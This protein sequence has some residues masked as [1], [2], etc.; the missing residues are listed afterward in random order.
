VERQRKRRSLYLGSD[1]YIQLAVPQEAFPGTRYHS[2]TVKAWCT[3]R[4]LPLLIKVGEGGAEFRLTSNAPV[5]GVVRCLFGPTDPKSALTDRQ[6][7]WKLIAQLSPNFIGLRTG[8]NEHAL[9]QLKRMLSLYIPQGLS[10]HNDRSLVDGV[11]S[12]ETKVMQRIDNTTLPPSLVR[13]IG[14]DLVLK[15]DFF[16][17][18]S[19]FLFGQ[20]LADLFSRYTGL[21]SFTQLRVQ[22]LPKQ[23]DYTWTIQHGD[24]CWL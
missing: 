5:R 21:H 22:S 10:G 3:N 16:D 23:F 4:D 1:V 18:H 19:L 15:L 9:R 11:V 8:E 2:I 12:F 7:D 20:V 14:I 6:S 17:G 24:R 13:G